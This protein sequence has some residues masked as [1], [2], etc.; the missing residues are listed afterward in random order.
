MYVF[1]NKYFFLLFSQIENLDLDGC[2]IADLG[3]DF[4]LPGHSNIELRRGGRDMPVTIHNLHQ[5]ISLV[6]HWFMVE[7]VSRQFEAFREGKLKKIHINTSILNI[8]F[9]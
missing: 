2:P 7:G 9:F 6:T 4:I 5:Y 1:S 8:L 3:L